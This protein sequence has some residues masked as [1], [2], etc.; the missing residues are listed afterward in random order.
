M[1]NT[2]GPLDRHTTEDPELTRQLQQALNELD[3]S[4]VTMVADFLLARNCLGNA[5]DCCTCPVAVFLCRRLRIDD[6]TTIHVD[7][8]GATWT[9]KVPGAGLEAIH[10]GWAALPDVVSNFISDLDNTDR[11]DDLKLEPDESV[12]LEGAV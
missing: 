9:P 2:Q 11:F 3:L 1:T 6:E 5:G 7:E 4:D 8:G 12:D 10:H